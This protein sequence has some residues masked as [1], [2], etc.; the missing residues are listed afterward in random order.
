MFLNDDRVHIFIIVDRN[1][2]NVNLTTGTVYR[3]RDGGHNQIRRP[4]VV[5]REERSLETRVFRRI[6]SEFA[7]VGRKH[8]ALSLMVFILRA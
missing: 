2:I 5:V 3:F 4:G 8:A 7:A 1:R 6:F